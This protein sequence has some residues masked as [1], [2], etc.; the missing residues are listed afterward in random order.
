ML[1]SISGSVLAVGVPAFM[2]DLHASRLAEPLDGLHHIAARATLLAAASD[3]RAA[4][5]ESVELTP[6]EVPAGKS[7]LDPPGT[8]EHPTWKRLEFRLERPHYYAFAF[9][10]KASVEGSEFTARAHGDLD[11]DGLLSSFRLSGEYRLG[12]EPIVYPLEMDREVE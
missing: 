4:Y 11:G 3:A 2:R 8:W 12:G 6:S 10:S 9:D 1:V 7:V 5:P